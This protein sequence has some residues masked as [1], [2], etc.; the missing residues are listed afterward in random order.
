MTM[1]MNMIMILTGVIV[2]IL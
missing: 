2:V 1:S